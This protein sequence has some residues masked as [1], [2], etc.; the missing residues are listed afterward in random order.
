MSLDARLADRA[1]LKIDAFERA[2]GAE[3]RANSVPYRDRPLLTLHRARDL[4]VRQRTQLINAMRA[5]LAELGLVAARGREGV[6]T[7]IAVVRSPS[8][9]GRNLPDNWP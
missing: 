9:T 1:H 7:L 4:P 6:Q 2:E 8:P 5:H 3:R